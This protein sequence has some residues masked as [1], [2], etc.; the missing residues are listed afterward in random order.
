MKALLLENISKQ[1]KEL[2]EQHNIQ[3]DYHNG[4]YDLK[5]VTNIDTYDIIGIRSKTILDKATIDLA[6]NL[7]VIGSFCIGT[8]KVDLDYC[9]SRGIAVFNSPVMSTR[10]VAELV[11]AHI[12]NLSRK[13]TKRNYEM[14][15]GIWNK[16]CANSNEIRG[17]TIGIIGYGHVGSQV[18]VLAEALGMN[19]LFYD[20]INVMAL[21]NSIRCQT[22]EEVLRSSDF[23]TI[24]V[25]LT[26]NTENLLDRDGINMMKKGAYL[27]NLSRGKVI[28]LQALRESID[29]DHLGGCALDV[30]PS[31]PKAN[32]DNWENIMQHAHNTILT[33]HIGGATEEA[34]TNIG[35]DV[36]HKIINYLNRGITIECLTLPHINNSSIET[37]QIVN[38]HHNIPGVISKISNIITSYGCNI[39]NSVL[40]TNENIGVCLI[41]IKRNPN[42]NMNTNNLEGIKKDINKIDETLQTYIVG[43]LSNI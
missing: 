32:C 6:T 26:E 40:S 17:K 28:D 18:S 2:L 3:V 35:I 30:Y 34:Q 31:E 8:D 27:L 33:P 5:K 41:S 39:V 13:V 29:D 42:M 25:P 23:V 37:H 10:S 36:S 20:I 19:V 7:K 14:H 21:G 38:V 1:A 16:T 24:H 9:Q 11:I 12:I 4:S 22:M 43:S 15:L